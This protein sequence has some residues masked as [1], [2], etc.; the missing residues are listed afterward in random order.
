MRNR[1]KNEKFVKIGKKNKWVQNM[2]EN[3]NECKVEIKKNGSW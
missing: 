2:N 1:N 3:K